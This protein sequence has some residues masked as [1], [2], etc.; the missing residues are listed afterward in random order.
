[1]YFNM[2]LGGGIE[3]LLTAVKGQ[4]PNR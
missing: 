2:V 4:C 1:M 3:P